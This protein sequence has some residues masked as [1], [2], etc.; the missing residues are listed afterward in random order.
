MTTRVPMVAALA[1]ALVAGAACKKKEDKAPALPPAPSISA[2]IPPSGSDAGGD[3]VMIFGASFV[4]GATLSLGGTAATGA[5]VSAGGTLLTATTPA[6]VAGPVNVVV[7]NPDGQSGTLANGYNYVF[8]GTSPTVTS[9]NPTVASPLGGTVVTIT[10]TNFSTSGTTTVY[11]GSAAGSNVTVTS[12]TT[13]VVTVPAGALGATTITVVNPSGLATVATGLLTYVPAPTITTFTPTSGTYTGGT[14]VTL[15]GTNFLAGATVTVAGTPAASVVIV[16]ATTI[17]LVTPNA[18][19]VGQVPIQVTNPDGQFYV[20]N[21]PGFVYIGPSPTLTSLNPASGATTGGTITT[22]TG[23]NF[24][25][26]A[27]VRFGAN[28]ATQVTVVNSTTITCRTPSGPA[29][30]VNVTVRNTDNNSVT[31]T[32]GYTYTLA[33]TVSAVTPAAGPMGGGQTVTITGTNFSN[34]PSTPTVTFG[35]TS[36]A[37]VTYVN[38]TTL[39]CVTPAHALGPVTVVVTNPDTQTGSLANAYTFSTTPTVTSINPTSDLIG[40]GTP[41][42]ITGTS[43]VVGATATIG[44]NLIGSITVVSA[45]TITGFTPSVPTAGVMGVTV[46]NPGPYS[47]TLASAF[48]YRYGPND[49]TAKFQWDTTL[50]NSTNRWY[51]DFNTYTAFTTDAAG[52]GFQTSTPSDS[53]NAY[54]IDWL[55]FYA[56]R[57]VSLAYGRTA[58][59]QPVSGSSIRVSFVGLPPASGNPGGTGANDFS[60][61]CVGG[62]TCA[63]GGVVG[64]SIYDSGTPNCGNSAEDD[65]RG[66]QFGGSAGCL[67]VF[68]GSLSGSL[69]PALTQTDLPYL[70]GTGNPADARYGAIHN[71]MMGWMRRVGFVAAHEMGHSLGLYGQNSGGSCGGST[72]CSATGSHN[73]CCSGSVI[74]NPSL[75]STSSDTSQAHS[76]K[77]GSVAAAASCYTGGTSCWAG[78]T[79]WFGT[80]P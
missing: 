53:V 72:L 24:F 45:T 9:V 14:A 46:T 68:S 52:K 56:L 55:R 16:S 64:V 71:A 27:T 77:P 61:E 66:P 73:G 39:R 38:S 51:L 23:T 33:P 2:V 70:D 36:A 30:Q 62:T 76:G 13:L 60:R 74:M 48:T 78:L 41:L 10:G 5:V 15:T 69:S 22:L 43:F 35:G 25:P 20:R 37:S 26:F 31:L 54:A 21:F 80:S 42:T 34:T 79:T 65:C 7:T 49:Q 11:F 67:G 32:N 44:P 19:Q 6:G 57:V 75:G 4:S 63:G 58:T 40:G 59:G 17:T 3:T 1:L 47:A 18:G 28:Y 29:T 8:A 50:V 12:T